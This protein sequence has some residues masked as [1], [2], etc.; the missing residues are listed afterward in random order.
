MTTAAELKRVIDRITASSTSLHHSS[1]KSFQHLSVQFCLNKAEMK[2]LVPVKDLSILFPVCFNPPWAQRAMQSGLYAGPYRGSSPW[3]PQHTSEQ[4]RRKFWRRQFES[5]GSAATKVTSQNH[6]F[7]KLQHFYKGN[8]PSM[9][10]WPLSNA[11]F[12]E[13]SHLCP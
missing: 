10:L 2:P 9:Q 12:S 3:I 11:F 8:Y 4:D 7:A 6:T 5:R 1:S 13:S